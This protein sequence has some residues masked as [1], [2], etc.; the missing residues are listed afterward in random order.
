MLLCGDAADGTKAT[1]REQAPSTPRRHGERPA[2]AWTISRPLHR[3]SDLDHELLPHIRDW[4]AGVERVA[5]SKY[6]TGPGEAEIDSYLAK[7]AFA[8]AWPA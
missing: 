6:S 2:L 8:A 7:G 3:G 4:A 1:G 5:E